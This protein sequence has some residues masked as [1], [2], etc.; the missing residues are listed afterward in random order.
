MDARREI[1]DT[2]HD[3]METLTTNNERPYLSIVEGKLET[4]E[5]KKNKTAD[6]R[7][8]IALYKAYIK[9]RKDVSK[10]VD[11]ADAQYQQHS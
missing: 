11:L 4:L 1:A 7:H 3:Y 9:L 8:A 6:D 2:L 5:K 10:I